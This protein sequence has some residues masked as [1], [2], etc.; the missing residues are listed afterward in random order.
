MS[1]IEYYDVFISHA[2]KNA[3][4]ANEIRTYLEARGLKCWIAPR[5]V[6]HGKDYGDEILRGIE[7]SKSFVLLVSDAANASPHVKRE[8]ERAVNYAKP[9]FP[10]R[11]EDVAL[12]GALEYFISTTH[13]IDAFG[14]DFLKHLENLAGEIAKQEN[15]NL[16]ELDKATFNKLLL[17]HYLKAYKYPLVISILILLCIA[18]A[19]PSHESDE[20]QKH[21]NMAALDQQLEQPPTARF[22]K[23]EH[24]YL[25][26]DEKEGRFLKFI[27]KHPNEIVNLSVSFP[28]SE[29]SGLARD[30]E[31]VL[32]FR[33]KDRYG[34][35]KS[36]YTCHYINFIKNE[37]LD[38]YREWDSGYWHIT[39]F[40]RVERTRTRIADYDCM[41]FVNY[42]EA[43]PLT[44][45][46]TSIM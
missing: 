2:S 20:F 36:D 38:R 40:F 32:S 43:I 37:A 25:D 7:K 35:D 5:D 29:E 16:R 9:V 33:Q 22:P 4:S 30:D 31:S 19:L 17:L 46:N 24:V 27:G 3:E 39:G 26:N 11:I 8:L 34:D 28:G 45:E 21:S 12:S 41:V 10:I 1:E 13:T 6:R 23:L 15:K 18:L 42:L 14:G 44:N